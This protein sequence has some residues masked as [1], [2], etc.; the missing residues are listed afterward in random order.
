MKQNG[1]SVIELMITM[2]IAIILIAIAIPG[3]TSF[4]ERNKVRS[5]LFT[6]QAHIQTARESAVFNNNT[7]TM[8]PLFNGSCTDFWNKGYTIFNDLNA[9]RAFDPE[10]TMISQFDPLANVT[11]LWNPVKNSN[12]L[13][14]AATGY[15]YKTT[16]NGTFSLCSDNAFVP[17]YGIIINRQGRMWVGIDKNRDKKLDGQSSSKKIRC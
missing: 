4:I 9:N 17:A 1:F 8:C 15:T 6:L 2:A 12:A 16:Q 11:L 7:V 10:D 5:A 13:Q 14:Y 3:F